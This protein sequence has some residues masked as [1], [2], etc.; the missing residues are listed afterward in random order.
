MNEPKVKKG[1]AAMTPEKRAE[2]ARLGG[3][4]AHAQ[5]VAH[6]WTTDTA[7]KAGS[8]GGQVSRG[9]RGRLPKDGS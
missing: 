5:G 1:F 3:V 8:K 9:G 2:I 7:R 4:A 6:Q